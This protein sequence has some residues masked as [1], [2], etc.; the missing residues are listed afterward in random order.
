MTDI[1]TMIQ[2]TEHMKKM[3]PEM[4]EVFSVMAQTMFMKYTALREAG[5]SEQQALQLC[6]DLA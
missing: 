4:A 2:A 6:K 5:F 1:Y 3:L